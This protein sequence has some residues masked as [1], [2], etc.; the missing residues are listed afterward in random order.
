VNYAELSANIQE[1]IEQPFTPAQIALF[2]QQTEQKLYNI[3]DLPAMR[4]NQTG[5]VTSGNKYLTMPSRILF[6]YSLAVAQPDGSYEYLLNKDVNFIREAYPSAANG[7]FPKYYAI[8]DEDT[9]IIGPTPDANYTA[10]IHFGTYPES[11]V[12]AGTT[13]LGEEF[14]SALLNGALVEAARF[15]KAEADQMQ[16]YDGMFAQ[17]VALLKTL[18]DGK[19]RQDTYR[20]GQTRMKVG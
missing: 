1:I 2:V 9:F 12:T 20:S 11:I 14:D 4:K 13:F 16:M 7:G 19:L 3:V 8:F 15:I 6:V 17:S 18:S 5:S 10:E